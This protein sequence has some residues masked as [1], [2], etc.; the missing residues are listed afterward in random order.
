MAMAVITG[1]LLSLLDL[2]LHD[3]LDFR[4]IDQFK[5]F[6]EPYPFN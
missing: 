2:L 5:S 3:F 4:N 6:N 1:I